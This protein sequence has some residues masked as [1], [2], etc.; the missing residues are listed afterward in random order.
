MTESNNEFA[1]RVGFC[2]GTGRCGTT[3]ISLLADHEPDV[4]SFHERERLGATF[5]MFCKWHNI[6]IDHEGF[7]RA[8]ENQI[9]DDLKEHR[10]SLESSALLSHSLEELYER[11]HARFLLLIRSPAETV[12]SFAVRGWFLK[13]P[14]RRDTSLPPSYHTGEEARHFLGRNIPNGREFDRWAGLT[15]I[16]RIAW[17]WNARNHAILEQFRE[18]PES[19]CRIQRLEDFDLEQYH[20]MA[21]FMGWQSQMDEAT[22]AELEQS[23]PNAGPNPPR[24]FSDWSET[25]LAEFEQEV[26]PV[27]EAVGYEYRGETL[28]EREASGTVIRE[29]RLPPLAD[30]LKKVFD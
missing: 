4:A 6:T 15:Q 13:T 10:F 30:V 29:A 18:L 24:R 2:I 27:A 28:R 14:V 23:R 3:L 9:R 5:H 26:A 25:E 20:A 19:H 12:A 16:G 8:K 21:R 17:F 11:F 7:L 22:F 1:G